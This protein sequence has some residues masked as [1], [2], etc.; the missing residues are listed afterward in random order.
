MNSNFIYQRI[1]K[2]RDRGKGGFHL[3]KEKRI[4]CRVRTE[5]QAFVLS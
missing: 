3:G 5:N 1:E 2:F 4:V